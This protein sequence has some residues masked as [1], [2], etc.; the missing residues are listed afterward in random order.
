M[1]PLTK[2]P[3][4]TLS[5]K[6]QTWTPRCFWCSPAVVAGVL[7]EEPEPIEWKEL[8]VGAER[9][10]WW[11]YSWGELGWRRNGLVQ[12]NNEEPTQEGWS[13]CGSPENDKATYEAL[14]KQDHRCTQQQKKQGNWI[15]WFLKFQETAQ[16]S[17]WKSEVT[18]KRWWNGSMAKQSKSAWCAVGHIHRQLQEWRVER[19]GQKG[20][21]GE[22]RQD[23]QSEGKAG[24]FFVNTRREPMPGLIEERAVK[25]IVGRWWGSSVWSDVASAIPVAA[26][27]GCGTGMW[28]SL[29]SGFGRLAVHKKCE[30]VV[31]GNS[32]DAENQG[33]LDDD[34]R[35]YEQV[36]PQKNL[37]WSYVSAH[38]GVLRLGCVLLS[39]DK[40]VC[41][42]YCS[43]TNPSW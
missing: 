3:T 21:R 4:V 8:H 23:G 27:L 24:T 38:W 14:A 39:G 30:T 37:N 6:F 18:A 7:Q 25:R 29:H 19:G 34:D 13:N 42:Y 26:P 41:Q 5:F 2:N 15:L 16:W 31:G 22:R 40:V 33:L 28:V 1:L 32:L 9:K 35:K 43:N 11:G 12:K 10:A 20:W 36:R 17:K